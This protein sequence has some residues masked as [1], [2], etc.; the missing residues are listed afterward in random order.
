MFTLGGRIASGRGPGAGVRP[1]PLTSLI[2]GREKF[3]KQS[4]MK[5]TEERGSR[6]TLI[7]TG[8]SE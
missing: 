4:E 5:G 8:P 6:D 3:L 2:L 1:F 7:E